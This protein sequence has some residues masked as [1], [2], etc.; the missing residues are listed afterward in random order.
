MRQFDDLSP[1]DLLL[2][3]AIHLVKHAVYLPAVYTQPNLPQIILADGMLMYYLDAAEVVNVHSEDM[4]WQLAVDV[5]WE[6]GAVDILGSV[7]QVCRHYLDAPVPDWVLE[8]LPVRGQ[9]KLVNRTHQ[10][11]ADYELQRYLGEEQ[12]WLWNFLLD[13]NGAFILRPIRILDTVSYFFPSSDYQK[14]RYGN[15]SPATGTRHFLKATGQYIRLSVDTIYYTWER[16]RRLKKLNK[17]ASLFNRL[18]TEG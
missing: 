16:Y 13:T 1:P 9:S 2:T 14:R 8:A 3:V 17:S 6:S 15:T 4:D 11:V 12:S 10:R 7:L 5:A 18:E